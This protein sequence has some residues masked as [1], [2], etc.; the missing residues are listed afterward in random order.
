MCCAAPHYE[1]GDALP[2][3]DGVQLERLERL[4]LHG[5]MSSRELPDGAARK[6]MRIFPLEGVCMRRQWIPAFGLA[7]TIALSGY[8]V[9]QL[10]ENPPADAPGSAV[11][12]KAT[13]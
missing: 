13:P 1:T 5:G 8:M 9:I 11:T 2:R 7:A 3:L 4:S 10:S 12:T 6:A